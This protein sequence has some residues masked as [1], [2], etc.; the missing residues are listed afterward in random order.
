MNVCRLT[1]SLK[2]L[3]LK[4]IK[5]CF[6]YISVCVSLFSLQKTSNNSVSLKILRGGIPMRH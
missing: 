5:Y 3:I 4:F 1:I 2:M 6:V